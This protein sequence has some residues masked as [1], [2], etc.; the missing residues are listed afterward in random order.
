MLNIVKVSLY[1]A[2]APVY[3]FHRDAVHLMRKV[4]IECKKKKNL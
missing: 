4:P 2:M 1:L 3:L